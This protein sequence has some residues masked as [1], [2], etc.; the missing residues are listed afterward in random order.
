MKLWY[1]AP[2]REWLE[3][4]PIG[5]GRL[6]A[7]VMGAH[8]R[9]RLALNHE[10]LWSGINRERDTEPRHERLAAVRKLLLAGSYA[11]GTLAAN[12]AFA[13][14]GGL[15]GTPGRV[16]PYQPAG[17]LY[18]EFDHGP[19]KDYRRELDLERAVATVSY[20]A[21]NTR[22]VREYIAHL[23]RDLILVRVRR[24][25]AP[26]QCILWL[27][28]MS[29][30]PCTLSFDTQEDR[31]IMHG[32]I[33]DGIDFQVRVDVRQ[34]GGDARILD[35]RK[36]FLSG[37][38]E[39]IVALNIGVTARGKTAAAEIA[40]CELDEQPDW[41]SLVASHAAEHQHHFGSIRLELDLEEPDLPTDERL[42]RVRAGE[43]DPA[44][45]A[46]YF[47]YGRY[48]LCAS[49]ANA[50]LPANL[51]GKWNEDL[52]PPWQCDYHHDINL[53]MCYWIAEPA[54][55]QS[56]AEGLFQHIERFVPHARK[57]ASDLYGCRGVY[58]PIQTDAWGRA[59]PESFGWAVWIGAAPWLA[60]HLWW[61]FEYGQD[62]DFLRTRAYPFF[63]DV[64]AFYEDYLIEDESGQLQIVPSQSPENQ[65]ADGG[66]LPVGLG[67]SATMDVILAH[68][69]IGY[70]LRSAE[71]LDIDPEDRRR[72][73]DMLER[74][75]RLKIGGHGQLQEWNED[76]EEAEPG[77]RHLSHLI[78]VYPGDMLGPQRT[79]ELWRAAEVS[80]ERRLAAGGG[81]SGWSRS[82][83]A[84]LFARFGRAAE[85]WH[86]LQHL[87]SDFATD[88]LMDLHPPR[89]FQIDGNLGGPAAIIEMFLQSYHGELHLLPALPAAWPVGRI[90]GLR[91]RGGFTVDLEWS[92]GELTH[93]R[94]RSSVNC[95]CTILHAAPEWQVLDADGKPVAVRRT[96]HR[97]VFA[98]AG[99]NTY[100]VTLVR[101][102]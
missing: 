36:L 2:P 45:A 42:R 66:D 32:D 49:S 9:D 70:A 72:W 28:R 87:I 65:F 59:T 31:L 38:T 41:D 62:L 12:E 75:P 86:H 89:I 95:D 73:Q 52:D 3:G 88:S 74:L 102:R 15:S 71:L 10:W 29:D 57:A 68:N 50:E 5:T 24:D 84:C 21:G 18:M 78:G 17:D 100:G 76:L 22:F 35:G 63:R 19:L 99:G 6:A 56:Y 58:F 48:L 30:E 11:Q 43:E 13:G 79:P 85:A 92:D 97:I 46:L 34:C 101:S 61:H 27:D 47:D 69:A 96:G 33:R 26:F 25:G 8:K 7:M 77:H 81:Q 55:M 91:A 64:A 44:L 94:L 40:E 60:Q 93:A 16:D 98:A 39:F 23:E 4:L 82:W 80:L 51:Q 67:V 90:E 37:M 83:V 54:G 14:G 53:Q 1:Q 20:S